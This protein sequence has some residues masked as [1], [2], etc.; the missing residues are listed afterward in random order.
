MKD[1]KN[2]KKNNSYLL[3]GKYYSN[4]FSHSG[5]NKEGFLRTYNIMCCS[6]PNLF[7][8]AVINKISL[9]QFFN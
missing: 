7:I 4:F 9:N 8:M 2:T 1:P 5:K 6:C 3:Y